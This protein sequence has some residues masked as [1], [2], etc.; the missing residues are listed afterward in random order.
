[1]GDLAKGLLLSPD[2]SV[3]LVLLCISPPT[4][5]MLQQI[6]MSVRS[7]IKE[8]DSTHDTLLLEKEAAFAITKPLGDS[9]TDVMF[10]YITFTSTALRKNSKEENGEEPDKDAKEDAS[11]TKNNEGEE[12]SETLP[13]DKCLQALAELRHSRWFAARAASLPSCVECIR[14]MKDLSRRDPIWASLSDW[15]VELLVERALYSAWRP[16]NPAASLM[17][18]MEVLALGLLLEESDTGLIDPCEREDLAISPFTNLTKQEKEDITKSA[19]YYLRLMHFRQ[20][21]RVL[22]MKMEEPE[23][24]KEEEKDQDAV[25]EEEENQQG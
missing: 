5:A 3:S 22:G 15:S 9:E 6:H 14:I 10:C 20:I 12:K 19:Q 18:V 24:G 1:M 23:D 7:K 13:V 16:L 8:I 2:R 17:R 21:Y 4:K 25:T 11:E